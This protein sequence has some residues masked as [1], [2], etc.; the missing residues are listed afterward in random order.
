MSLRFRSSRPGRYIHGD[1]LMVIEAKLHHLRKTFDDL[2]RREREFRSDVA[3]IAGDLALLERQLIP[4]K[5]EEWRR[6]MRE[7]IE[8]AEAGGE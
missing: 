7:A 8:E 2:D 6:Q 1:T 5:L 4:E 3:K